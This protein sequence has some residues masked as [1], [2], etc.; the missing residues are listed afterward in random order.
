MI[1]DYLQKR[2][3]NYIYILHPLPLYPP[4]HIQHVYFDIAEARD[5]WIYTV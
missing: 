3:V 4:L 1:I 5:I 2:Y